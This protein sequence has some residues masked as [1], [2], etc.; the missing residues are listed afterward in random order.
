MLRKS[1]SFGSMTELGERIRKLRHDA[2]MSLDDLALIAK[3]SRA[4]I[5]GLEK[6]PSNPSVNVLSKI[7]DGLDVRL[8]DLFSVTH[9]QP[10]GDD[11]RMLRRGQL[12]QHSMLGVVVQ[13]AGREDHTAVLTYRIIPSPIN[14]NSVRACEQIMLL[15]GEID[16]WWE[17]ITETGRDATVHPGDSVV[18]YIDG[19]E[20]MPGLYAYLM[21]IKADWG[22]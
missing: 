21:R 5:W 18:K 14:K 6:K 13:V 4:Y 12:L 16:E 1:R 10:P 22:E 11:S 3:V 17:P 7:A 9:R 20:D 2:G 15:P 19:A 8:V